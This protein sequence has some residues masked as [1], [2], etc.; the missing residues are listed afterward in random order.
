M[1][2]KETRICQNC[3][4]EF[5]VESEDIEFYKK[6]NIPGPTFCHLCRRERLISWRNERSLYHRTCPATGKKIISIFRPDSP[7]VA[8]DRDYWWSDGWDPL[9]YGRDYDFSKP[10]FTQFRELFERVPM[11]AVFNAF[12][13]NSNYCN[14]IGKSKDCY[15][16]F[17]S[18]ENE[19]LSYSAQC[20][21]CR[22]SVDLLT[23]NNCELCYE[24]IKGMKLYNVL[25]AENSENCSDSAFLFDCKG[26]QHCFGCTNLRNKSYYFFN[27][28][29]SKEEYEEKIKE[30]DLGKLEDVGRARKLFEEEKSRSIRR[31]AFFMNTTNSTGD[32]LGQCESCTYCFGLREG[33][34]DCKYCINGGYG[35]YDTYDSFG[36]GAGAE[37][38]YESIDTG[39][40]GSRL[41]FNVAVYGSSSAEYSYNCHGSTN[42]FGCVGLKGKEYCI[43]NQQYT[44][45]EYEELI[46]KIKAHMDE[47]PYEDKKGRIY[48]YG[49]FFPFDMCPYAYNDTKAHEHFPLSENEAKSEGFIWRGEE[50]RDYKITKRGDELP[51]NIQ[52]AKDDIT[53]E[54][55]ACAHEGKCDHGC[56]T[57]FRITP[58]ELLLYKKM[59]LSLPRMCPTCRYRERAA[60]R[61][62]LKLWKRHCMCEGVESRNGIYRNT[63]VHDHGEESCPREFETNYDP[64]KEDIVYCEDCYNAEVV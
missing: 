9:D 13:V 41:L 19:N 2:Q 5:E 63:A 64:E 8:Y 28:P 16:V 10:F 14:H 52:D 23:A 37:L 61:N 57:A 31:P 32:Y 29:H 30:F 26:C 33:A 44:K 17:A 20:G 11:P 6:L 18:W 40:N 27:Q 49:E 25:F 22:D 7:I 43:L 35:L 42:L 59:H 48:K 46:P 38:V 58:Q 54:I 51:N 12:C 56:T 24:I 21:S 60:R 36:C 4:T 53:K 3:K 62:P 55:I 45:E 1:S 39:F 15:L 50:K 34:K 47:M